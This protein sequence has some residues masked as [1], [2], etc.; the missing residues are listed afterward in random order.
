MTTADLMHATDWTPAYRVRGWIVQEKL[1]GWRALWDGKRLLTR[2]GLPYNAPQWFLDSLPAG[3]PLDGELYAG[4][5]NMRKIAGI[6]AG[7][8]LGLG[9]VA[10]DAPTAPGDYRARWSTA[11]SAILGCGPF[12]RLAQFSPL[13]SLPLLRAALAQLHRDG[14]EG[15]MLRDPRA[16]YVAGRTRTMMKFKSRRLYK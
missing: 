1:D 2:Q 7:D 16:G 10:F 9:F 14:G 4:R 12:V 15:F 5:G 6:V 13:Q 3:V 11:Q 8:W